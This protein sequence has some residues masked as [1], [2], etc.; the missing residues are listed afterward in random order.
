MKT[1]ITTGT[2]EGFFKR[3]KEIARL[4]DAG[5]PIPPLRII[6]IEDPEDIARLITPA[7]IAVFHAV[8]E[9]ADSITG[10]AL[11]LHRDRSAVKRDVD[12]L[13]KFGLVTVE[14]KVLPGHG[15]MKEVSATA[16]QVKLEAYL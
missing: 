4:A 2:E 7:K 3:G 6:S 12:E 16:R 8:K 15:Q 9:H 14:I 13:E 10:I 11:R 1:T 5:E